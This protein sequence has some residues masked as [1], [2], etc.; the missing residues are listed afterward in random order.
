MILPRTVGYLPDNINALHTLGKVASDNIRIYHECEAGIEK[1]ILRI[2][3][4]HHKA[5]RVM[6]KVMVREEFY[7]G[8][9]AAVLI[10]L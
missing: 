5:C 1:S 3:D 9:K 6:T 4:W 8:Q 7:G 2:T 10:S